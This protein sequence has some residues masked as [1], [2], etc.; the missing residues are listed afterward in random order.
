MGIFDNLVKADLPER[1]KSNSKA[2]Q[3]P[4]VV[5]RALRLK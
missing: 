4:A 1:N 2:D 3:E 5:Y